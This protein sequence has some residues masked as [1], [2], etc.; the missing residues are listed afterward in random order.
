MTVGNV[1]LSCLAHEGLGV[2]TVYALADHVLDVVAVA[3]SVRPDYGHDHRVLFARIAAQTCLSD[4][5][6]GFGCRFI[7]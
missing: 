2:S 7:D 3:K 5:A 1:A 4:R 6:V